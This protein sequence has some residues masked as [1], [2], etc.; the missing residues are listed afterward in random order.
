[1]AWAA[2]SSCVLAWAPPRCDWMHCLSWSVQRPPQHS[3]GGEAR[4]CVCWIST[5]FS[6][7]GRSELSQVKVTRANLWGNQT[8]FGG[9]E[10][11]EV[12]IMRAFWID[13]SPPLPSLPPLSSTSNG[14][15]WLSRPSWLHRS[16]PASQWHALNSTADNDKGTMSDGA[17]S[18]PRPHSRRRLLLLLLLPHGGCPSSSSFPLFGVTFVVGEQKPHTHVAQVDGLAEH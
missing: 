6:F 15:C 7:S 5:F 9:H 14:K 1:M 11:S 3:E 16:S 4:C 8:L 2:S 17:P 18:P 13:G 12:T 10:S